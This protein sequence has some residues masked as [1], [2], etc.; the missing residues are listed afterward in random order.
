MV[1][2]VDFVQ[3]NGTQYLAGL[4]G[5]VPAVAS[6]ELGS[7]VGKVQCQLS[8]LKFQAPPGPA[9]DGDAAFIAVGTELH[10]IQGYAPSCRLAARIGGVNRVYLAHADVAGVS[11]PVACAKQP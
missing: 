10:A 6:E 8:K 11:K 9:V 7:A 1:D 2:W 3:L 4:D 5:N